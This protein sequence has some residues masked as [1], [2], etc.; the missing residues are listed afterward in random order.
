VQDKT[1]SLLALSSIELAATAC[2]V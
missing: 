1:D 2:L